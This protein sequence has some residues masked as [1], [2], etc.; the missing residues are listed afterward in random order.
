[1]GWLPRF[2]F[3]NRR[4]DENQVLFLSNEISHVTFYAEKGMPQNMFKH[5]A[6]AALVGWVTVVAVGQAQ[7][8]EPSWTT[9]VIKRGPERQVSQSTDILYRPYRPL[10]FYGNTVRRLHY[11]GRALPT[12]QDL[13]ITSRLLRDRPANTSTPR[14][15]GR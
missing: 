5:L 9:R 14:L 10:H 2:I 13:Q 1:M 3:G 11:Q 7:A 15:N 4:T 6:M 8:Q 12:R